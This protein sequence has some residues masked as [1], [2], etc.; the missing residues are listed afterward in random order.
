MDISPRGYFDHWIDTLCIIS[1]RRWSW[2]K[3]IKEAKYWWERENA[4][5]RE[6]SIVR[7]SGRNEFSE[8]FSIHGRAWMLSWMVF[9]A[10]SCLIQLVWCSLPWRFFTRL[11]L[12]G[13]ETFRFRDAGQCYQD[14]DGHGNEIFGV[15]FNVVN[16]IYHSVLFLHFRNG[17]FRYLFWR[18]LKTIWICRY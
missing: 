8:E 16:W 7:S 5:T 13:V 9:Q 11:P 1:C 4:V 2:R 6:K 14:Y 3:E 17:N 10:F 12:F 18:L 15:F